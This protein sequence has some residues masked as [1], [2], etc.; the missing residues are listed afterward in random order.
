MMSRETVDLTG[1][2]HAFPYPRSSTG[3]ITDLGRLI[4]ARVKESG[5]ISFADYMAQCLYH[6][7]LGYYARPGKPT[8]SKKGDFIT[9]V[10]VGSVFGKLLAHRLYKFWCANGSPKTFTILEPGAHDG[11]LCLDIL[12][13]ISNFAPEFRSAIDYLVHEPLPVRR[14]LLQAKLQGEASV[15]ASPNDCHAKIGA[16]IANEILDALPVP[17]YLRSNDQWHEILVTSNAG[18]LDWASWPAKPDLPKNLPEGYVT[19]GPPE[20]SSFMTP[21]ARMFENALFIWIDY[22]L[23]EEALY[24]PARTAG[25]LRCY[26]KHKTCAHPLENPGEQDLT[27]DVNFTAVEKFATS[28]DLQIHP[29]MNQSRYLTYCGKEWLLSNPSQKEISQFQTLIH[30]TQFGGR[31]YA[32]EMTKGNVDPASLI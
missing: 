6:H 31:F 12:Q 25:T 1:L 28:L 17:L 3:A 32:L 29:A 7:E 14:K 9:S 20:L 16:L 26:F 5:P 8:V 24:H 10:S 19:E 15:I 18:S 22:G 4:L 13:A 2:Q 11:T 27:A 30:P 21:L 23:D